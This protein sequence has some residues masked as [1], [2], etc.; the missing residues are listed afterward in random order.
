MAIAAIRAA[1]LDHLVDALQEDQRIAGAVLVGSGAVGFLDEESD[2][3]V[4]AAVASAHDATAVYQEWGPLLEQRLPVVYR[5]QAGPF[6]LAHR[7]HGVLLD[8]GGSLL[9]LDFSFTPVT[10]LRAL[11]PRWKLLFDRTGEVH[12]RMVSPAPETP[13]LAASLQLFDQA[14]ACVLQCR[15][16]LRRGRTWN[17]ALALHELQERTLR[18]ACR[19]RFEEARDYSGA[20][21]FA[22]DLPPDLLA[23]MA[24]TNVPVE[25]AALTRALRQATAVM[26]AEAREL[27]QQS[28]A[29][30]PEAFAAAL[31]AH[32]D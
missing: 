29:V 13:P 16:A 31:V 3:D 28:G 10:D 12:A 2:L 11:R 9:E 7:L 21:R 32:L 1:L 25:R 4:V 8:A 17:A 18:I 23:A 14:C 19:V 22:D 15:K 30:F 6:Q 24:A 26:L 27:Y 20:E 5:G